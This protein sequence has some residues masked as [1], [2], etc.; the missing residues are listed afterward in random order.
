MNQPSIPSPQSNEN[1]PSNPT[2]QKK[3]NVFTSGCADERRWK[4]WQNSFIP[5]LTK[6]VKNNPSVGQ[7]LVQ[8]Y[9]TFDNNNLEPP[10]QKYEI[11]RQQWLEFPDE[12][13]ETTDVQ[14]V[15]HVKTP[16]V[17]R[18]G[19][20]IEYYEKRNEH[21]VYFDFAHLLDHKKPTI[22]YKYIYYPYEHTDQNTYIEKFKPFRFENN[23]IKTY[24]ED[25]RSNKYIVLQQEFKIN[26]KQK[27]QTPMLEIVGGT[28]IDTLEDYYKLLEI[29]RE[30]DLKTL[31]ENLKLNELL[32]KLKKLSLSD[33]TKTIANIKTIIEDIL[34]STS[35]SVSNPTSSS[36]SN[37]N[38]PSNPSKNDVA[39]IPAGLDNLGASCYANS[40]TQLLAQ[41]PNIEIYLRNAKLE[42]YANLIQ[43]LKENTTQGNVILNDKCDIAMREIGYNERQADPKELFSTIINKVGKNKIQ[44][45]IIK[46]KRI[47]DAQPLISSIIEI[48]IT[49]ANMKK[50]VSE[51]FSELFENNKITYETSQYVWIALNTGDN[52]T[53]IQTD[54]N[55]KLNIGKILY[56]LIGAIIHI[57]DSQSMGHYISVK[58]INNKWYKINDKAVEKIANIN[59]YLN[60]IKNKSDENVRMLLYKKI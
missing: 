28:N 13:K 32:E 45:I 46:T 17:I 34:K 10:P 49:S 20:T 24:I 4:Q 26:D 19:E 1:Q 29:I 43:E 16:N 57:G 33:T 5:W 58:Q 52:N 18:F 8:H 9:D 3:F 40:L 56:E 47:D 36:Q 25:L 42:N 22:P 11:I 55:E 53:N 50:S 7:L 59:M 39:I 15:K 12:F 38:Q 48:R 27:I 41:I 31:A 21:Y 60:D 23:E 14:T 37:E 35:I 6:F 54:V 44:E 30:F 51:L 2:E